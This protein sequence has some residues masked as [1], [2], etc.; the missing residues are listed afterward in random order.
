MIG[1]RAEGCVCEPC[2]D[3]T[4]NWRDMRSEFGYKTLSDSGTKNEG[5]L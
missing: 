2:S 5:I 3:R 1:V 4:P